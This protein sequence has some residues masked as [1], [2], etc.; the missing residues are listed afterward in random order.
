[1]GHVVYH[2]RLS[3]LGESFLKYL[4][5][6]YCAAYVL[7]LYKCFLKGYFEAFLLACVA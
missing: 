1:M 6:K 7:S 5:L 3:E 4:H 2:E